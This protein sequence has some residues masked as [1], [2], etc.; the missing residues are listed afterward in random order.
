M[1][2]GN[3]AVPHALARPRGTRSERVSRGLNKRQRANGRRLSDTKTII[4]GYRALQYPNNYL[5]ERSGCLFCACCQSDIGLRKL[6]IEQHIRSATHKNDSQ[7]K[8]SLITK[9]KASNI[10]EA[11]DRIKNVSTTKASTFWQRCPT[12]V[13]QRMPDTK[14]ISIVK[15]F[16]SNSTNQHRLADH[17]P[18][19]AS[20][21]STNIFYSIHSFLN[22]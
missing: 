15:E 11:V 6:P 1:F 13:L 21:G 2:T 9:R 4:P 20:F 8:K 3:K 14:S 17:I 7:K 12:S 22:I 5:E 18:V 19:R 16:E 10:E